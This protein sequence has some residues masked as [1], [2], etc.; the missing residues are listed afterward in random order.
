[1][2]GFTRTGTVCAL[3]LCMFACGGDADDWTGE[4]QT[5]I[6]EACACKDIPCYDAAR[7]KRKKMRKRFKAKYKN[8]K[9]EGKP[10]GKENQKA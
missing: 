7:A 9:G 6:D 2:T 3:A 5:I 4:Y 8:D 10:I 1:M